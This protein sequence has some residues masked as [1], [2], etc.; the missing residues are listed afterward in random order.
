MTFSV[1]AAEEMRVRCCDLLLGTQEEKVWIGTF[2][3][4][5]RNLLSVMHA[6][7]LSPWEPGIEFIKRDSENR[8][9]DILVRAMR[10]QDPDRNQFPRQDKDILQGI[11]FAKSWLVSPE[12]YS[13]RPENPWDV[14]AD[15]ARLVAKYYPLYQRGLLTINAMDFDDQLMQ[16]A[17]LLQRK[18]SL[19]ERVGRRFQYVLV[20]EFQDLNHAQYCLTRLFGMQGNIFAVGDED[21]AIYSWRGADAR[22][23]EHFQRDYPNLRKFVL[24]RN[25]RSKPTIL[26]PSQQIVQNN[27]SRSEKGLFTLRKA[28]Q[29]VNVHGA[30][31]ESKE[32]DY[33][34]EKIR[35]RSEDENRHEEWS[36]YAV[37]YRNNYQC[38][39]LK[40]ALARTCIPCREADDDTPLLRYVEIRDM[41][42]YLRLCVYPDDR[43]SF[44]RVINAPRRGIGPVTLGAFFDWI[45]AD[46]LRVSEALMALLDGVRPQRL[47]DHRRDLFFQ[48]AKF[49]FRDWRILAARDQLTKLLDGIREQ[50]DYD[51][52]IDIYNGSTDQEESP[53]ARERKGNIDLFRAQLERAE[54]EGHTLKQF[55]DSN[56]L[57]QA[58]R[59]RGKDAVT[60]STLHRAKG[61]EFPV[62]FVTGLEEELLPDY[63]ATEA[64]ARLEEERRL[65]YVGMTRAEDELY[66]TWAATRKDTFDKPRQN[67][68][69]R[70]LQEL[71]T[72][73]STRKA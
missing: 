34:A 35:L 42:A 66:L 53:K 45:R 20:D 54:A 2:H 38:K 37:L 41:L 47:T 31:N 11:S 16:T 46:G 70:F 1:K 49:L 17:L 25:F 36:D 56:E 24:R 50:T 9:R 19:R 52:Y 22:N 14:P 58:F 23:F 7:E 12:R 26:K 5:C 21:Q 6:E 65:F 57:A 40:A 30:A 27:T 18:R 44:Q 3:K 69:S 63:R 48:F 62:V 71:E 59:E 32:A 39:A 15:V 73:E 8:R 33:V 28:G 72:G 10:D 64:P 61:L 4:V 68:A 55:L 60:L 67:E 29:P 43:I 13:T 51:R